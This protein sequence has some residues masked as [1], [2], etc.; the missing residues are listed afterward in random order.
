[1]RPTLPDPPTKRDSHLD[2]ARHRAVTSK[3]L[4]Q[5]MKCGCNVDLDVFSELDPETR[6]VGYPQEAAI[7]FEAA[8]ERSAY[9]PSSM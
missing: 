4:V 5:Y 6:K 8:R 9:G 1:M 7:P 2:R 3:R